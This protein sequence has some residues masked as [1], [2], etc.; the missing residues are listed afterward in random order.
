[1]AAKARAI[2]F[3]LSLAVAFGLAAGAAHAEDVGASERRAP[4]E[5]AQELDADEGA[6]AAPQV[7]DDM[8]VRRIAPTEFEELFLGKTVYFVLPDGTPWG[9]EFYAPD[10]EQTVFVYWDGRCLQGRWAA[11]ERARYCFYYRDE[12]SCWATFWQGREIVVVSDDGMRQR[13]ERIVEDEPLS[14]EPELIG[15]THSKMASRAADPATAR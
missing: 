11:H 3:F 8:S 9:R 10:G 15:W 1:M 2:A 7:P 13:V 12:P 6:D 5:A 14:C 4:P